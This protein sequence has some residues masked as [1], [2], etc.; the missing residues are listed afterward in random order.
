MSYPL[1]D[2]SGQPFGRLVAIHRDGPG[3]W[4]C[5]CACG[6]QTSV[7]SNALKAGTVRSCGC[8][9]SEMAREGLRKKRK[10]PRWRKREYARW[11]N[12][13]ARCLNP[14]SI[15]WVFYGARGITVCKRWLSFE[16]F[17]ADMG[18]APGPGYSLDRI[19]NELGY[20]PENCRWATHKEQAGNRRHR[21]EGK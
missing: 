15:N 9:R 5:H 21:S 19:N 6:N 8:L 7:R 14:S 13:L 12:I 16:N 20:S 2:I 3:K 4:L 1:I 11:R 18:P 10:Y 17:I